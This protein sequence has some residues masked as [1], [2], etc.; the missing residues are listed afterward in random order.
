[1]FQKNIYDGLVGQSFLRNFAV[2]FDPDVDFTPETLKTVG[3]L[4]GVIRSRVTR[5]ARERAD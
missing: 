2:T 4:S 3:S 5:S 1:M